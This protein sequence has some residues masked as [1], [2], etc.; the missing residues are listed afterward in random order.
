MR[1]VPEPPPLEELDISDF[2]DVGLVAWEEASRPDG[3]RPP[4]KPLFIL[5][6]DDWRE[7]WRRRLRRL[8]NG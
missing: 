2:P 8:R 3:S 1:M 7:K 5:M 6:Y 4:S